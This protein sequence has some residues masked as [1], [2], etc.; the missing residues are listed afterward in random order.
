MISKKNKFRL[1][2][3]LVFGTVLSSCGI[4]SFTG[5]NL[6]PDIKT[7]SISTFP[8]NYGQGPSYLS[9]VV[10]T[11]IRDHFQRNT[12]LQMVPRDGD[13]I[14]EG[15]IIGFDFTPVAPQVQNGQD[16]AAINRLTLRIQV[17]F[18]NT[19]DPKQNFDQAFNGTQ[20]FPQNTNLNQIDESAI[21]TIVLDRIMPDIFTRSVANW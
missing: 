3:L 18:T 8:N 2:F 6:S 7:M 17:K 10:T 16:V 5:T 13:L 19:K 14:M 12:N 20:D 9:Q 1:L 11:T 21:R 15:Q 4:Y